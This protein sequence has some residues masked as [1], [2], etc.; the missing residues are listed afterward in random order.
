MPGCVRPARP[1]RCSAEAFEIF[2]KNQP[3]ETDVLVEPHDPNESRIDN[4]RH[5]SIVI[6]VSATFVASTILR[7]VAGAEHGILLLGGR[8]P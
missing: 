4:R 6:D 8:S 2:P 5:A 7:P 1:A 3:I